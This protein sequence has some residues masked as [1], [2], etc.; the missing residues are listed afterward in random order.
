MAEKQLEKLIES[1]IK[2][3]S[4]LADTVDKNEGRC[5]KLEQKIDQ[6]IDII[7]QKIDQRANTADAWKSAFILLAGL[8]LSLALIVFG[9]LTFTAITT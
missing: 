3:T 5:D 1:L 2:A 6:K 9:L 8:V 7:E 4:V